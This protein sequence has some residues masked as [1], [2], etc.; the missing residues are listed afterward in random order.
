[1]IINNP[2][3]FSTPDLTLSTSNSSGTA[4]AIRADDTVAVFDTSVA[5]TISVTSAGTGSAEVASRRDHVHGYALPSQYVGC[6]CHYNGSGTIGSNSYNISGVSKSTTG[7][8]V[9]TVDT[10]FNDANWTPVAIAE[11]AANSTVSIATPSA[12]AVTIYAFNSDASAGNLDVRM[13][14]IGTPA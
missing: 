10:D 11:T 2:T 1:M 7:V 13:A 5:S 6:F 9:V 12:G 4:G 14:G 8:T 3:T